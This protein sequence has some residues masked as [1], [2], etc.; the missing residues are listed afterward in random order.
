MSVQALSW[1][2]DFS[3]SSLAARHVL[4]SIA[5]HAKANGTGAWPSVSRLSR[6]ANVSE[7]TVHRSIK[8]LQ[9]LGELSVEVGAGPHGCNLYTLAK[10]TPPGAKLIPLGSQVEGGG[11]AK[12][13]GGGV[14]PVTPEPSFNRPL[15]VKEEHSSTI[16]RMK[17]DVARRYYL[18]RGLTVPA[19]L[20]E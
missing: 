15:T 8:E 18:T 14:P 6:E 9:D 2:F 4:L 11:G 19:H 17:K 1:V 10:M 3:K 20:Q 12:L 5:N 16:F 7:S 13:T